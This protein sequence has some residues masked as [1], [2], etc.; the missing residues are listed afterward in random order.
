MRGPRA[1]GFKNL[2]GGMPSITVQSLELL[3]EQKEALAEIFTTA[4]SEQTHVPKERI[5]VFFDGYKLDSLS[6]GG[7][8]LSK[9]PPKMAI[10]KFNQGEK[11]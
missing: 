3:D 6:T 2:E 10:A 7:Q 4:F 8:L 9:N 5:Y 1:L 11:D